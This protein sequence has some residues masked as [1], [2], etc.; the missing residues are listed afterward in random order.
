MKKTKDR[1]ES[2][3]VEYFNKVIKGYRDLSRL[4]KRRFVLLDGRKTIEELQNDILN[5]LKKKNK[6]V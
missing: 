5:I 2:K 1:M 3:K 6:Y 4:N